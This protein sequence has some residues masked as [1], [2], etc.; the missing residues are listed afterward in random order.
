[1][2][3]GLSACF[4]PWMWATHIFNLC[5]KPLQSLISHLSIPPLSLNWYHH[6]F[7]HAQ[8]NCGPLMLRCAIP[9]CKNHCAPSHFKRR[10]LHGQ[11]AVSVSS[12]APLSRGRVI[13]RFWTSLATGAVWPTDQG[14]RGGRAAHQ[15]LGS[16]RGE[17]LGAGLYSRAYNT[18]GSN[19]Q[20][21]ELTVTSG[22][23]G[24]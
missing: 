9:L 18:V 13:Y 16:Q 7:T 15:T 1:M 10:V 17:V 19:G 21:T 24:L 22:L 5:S 11:W 2:F 8:H 3:V 23:E 20:V 12:Q 14:S 6:Q 4:S